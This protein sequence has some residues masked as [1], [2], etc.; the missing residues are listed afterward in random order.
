MLNSKAFSQ[1]LLIGKDEVGKEVI[2]FLLNEVGNLR[3][4]YL[5]RIIE[6]KNVGLKGI[7]YSYLVKKVLV[8][9][10]NPILVIS[11]FFEVCIVVY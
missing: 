3:V 10:S 4:T 11:T 7:G 2:L 8:G 5:I 6:G 9:K 1:E